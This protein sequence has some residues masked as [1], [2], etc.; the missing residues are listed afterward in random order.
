MTSKII[1]KIIMTITEIIYFY[2]C[3]FSFDL[4]LIMGY[5]VSRI[6]QNLIV[7]QSIN[8]WWLNNAL[9][10]THSETG[11]NLCRE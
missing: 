6:N 4:R 8:Y 1:T 10:G 11:F 2:F 7:S 3:M 5:Q 9:P